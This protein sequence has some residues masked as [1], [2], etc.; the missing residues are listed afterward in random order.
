[1]DGDKV[2]LGSGDWICYQCK[3]PLKGTYM[4]PVIPWQH[5]PDPPPARD[6]TEIAGLETTE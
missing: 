5:R 2:L 4:R 6:K 1:M 3:R